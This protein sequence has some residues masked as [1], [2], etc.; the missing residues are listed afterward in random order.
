M[1][2]FPSLPLPELL[3]LLRSTWSLPQ[4]GSPIRISQDQR[5]FA[6]PLS[7]SQLVTSFFGSQC[8][9]IRLVLF[10]AWSASAMHAL[11]MV[12]L[13]FENNFD[14]S[15]AFAYLFFNLVKS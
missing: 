2:Q 1:F 14:L 9:G 6:P 12:F 5:I 10:F 4:V 7:F 15:I 11:C 8:Q 13:E 3:Y